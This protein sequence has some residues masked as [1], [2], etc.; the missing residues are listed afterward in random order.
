MCWA[1]RSAFLSA[2]LPVAMALVTIHAV[3][4]ITVDLVMVEVIR[5]VASMTLRALEDRIIVRVDVASRAHAI[6]VPVIRG[7]LRV[8]RV[9]ER[10]VQPAA[11]CMARLASR[12]EKLRLRRVAGIR[13]GVVIRLVTAD[14]RGRQR[15]VVVVHVAIGAHPRRHRVHA[16]QRERRVVVV[17]HAIRP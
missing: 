7:E 12:R 15:R 8:L 5:V 3:V 9:I 13:C 14:A 4:H 1:I 17:E 6:C 10:R 2:T 16:G 11:R